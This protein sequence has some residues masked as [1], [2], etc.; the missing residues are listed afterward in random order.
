[1][2]AV[3]LGLLRPGRGKAILRLDHPEQVEVLKEK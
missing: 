2:V 1:V 3:S